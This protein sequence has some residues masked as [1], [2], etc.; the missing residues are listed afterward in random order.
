MSPDFDI[1]VFFDGGRRLPLARRT[2]ATARRL[3]IAQHR[4]PPL[5]QKPPEAD[6]PVQRRRLRRSSSALDP[7]LNWI[8]AAVTVE[9]LLLLHFLAAVVM[10]AVIW[11]VQVVQ[12][13]LFA[14]IG[15]AEFPAYAAD[16]QRRIG[17]VV[18]GPMLVEVVT[19][20]ALATCR[21]EIYRH[22]AFAM[23]SLLLAVV[24]ACTFLWQ[25]PLHQKLLRGKD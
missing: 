24:W 1:E 18:I 2:D 25:V 15:E 10:A 11:F 3:G 6:R 19:A 17:W 20:V 23:A 13:P 9:T 22:P 16:Y 12:Y 7:E 5:R 8:G 14:Q 21:P 4:L